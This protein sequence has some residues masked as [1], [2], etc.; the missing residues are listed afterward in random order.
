MLIPDIEN[1][2]KRY[3]KIRM[4]YQASRDFSLLTYD[5]FLE[6]AKVTWHITAIEKV[7]VVFDVDWIN[8]SIKLFKFLIPTQVKLFSNDEFDKAKAWISE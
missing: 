7:T 8:D 5:T 4:L 6:D 2:I 3:K 1:K